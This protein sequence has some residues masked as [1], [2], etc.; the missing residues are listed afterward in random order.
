M[1][2]V[3]EEGSEKLFENC[4]PSALERDAQAR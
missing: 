3:Y 2:A 1:A 4:S